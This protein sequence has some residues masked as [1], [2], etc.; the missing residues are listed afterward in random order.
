MKKLSSL[1]FEQKDTRIIEQAWGQDGWISAKFFV[2]IIM[3]R[4]KV[5]VH[6]NAKK[7]L[8]QYPAISS[9]VNKGFIIWPKNF[10]LLLKIPSRQDG[11]ILPAW[12]TNQNTEFAS[13]CLLTEPAI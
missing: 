10:T 1:S 13:S 11:S 5:E 7:E 3:D 8:G 9:L 6:K 4:G 12:A 2:C